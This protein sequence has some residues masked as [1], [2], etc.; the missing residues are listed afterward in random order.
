MVF[1]TEM[2]EVIILNLF[3]LKFSA[4]MIAAGRSS[5]SSFEIQKYLTKV[6][7]QGISVTTY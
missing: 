6:P 1:R 7:G 4:S 5:E 2:M 3:L